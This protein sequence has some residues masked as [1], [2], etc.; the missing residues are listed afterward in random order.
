SALS[1][2]PTLSSGGNSAGR[3]GSIFNSPS[4][5]SSLSPNR[6]GPFFRSP[7]NDSGNFLLPPSNASLNPQPTPPTGCQPT[8]ASLTPQPIP[9]N[10]TAAAPPAPLPANGFP[11]SHPTYAEPNQIYVADLVTNLQFASP[12]DVTLI[13]GEILKAQQTDKQ[14]LL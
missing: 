9:P 6:N 10:Q 7:G 14:K 11:N 13:T 4:S 1:K 8:T 12:S 5:G 3:L 2:T